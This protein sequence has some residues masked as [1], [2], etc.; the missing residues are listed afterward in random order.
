MATDAH[1]SN[2]WVFTTSGIDWKYGPV[3]HSYKTLD[4]ALRKA[5]EMRRNGCKGVTVIAPGDRRYPSDPL[6]TVLG[7]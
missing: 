6:K 4:E 1:P 7:A 2:N 3:S 5:R